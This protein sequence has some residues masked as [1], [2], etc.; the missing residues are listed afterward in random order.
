MEAIACVDAVVEVVACLEG[1]GE[2][3][4]QVVGLWEQGVREGGA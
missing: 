1:R 2:G 4:R 3:D